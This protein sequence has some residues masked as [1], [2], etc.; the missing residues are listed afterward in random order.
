MK[1]IKTIDENSLR[2]AFANALTYINQ[3]LIA[4]RT[5]SEKLAINK[6]ALQLISNVLTEVGFIKGD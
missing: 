5:K 4:E 3:Q 2:I 6:I 1:R